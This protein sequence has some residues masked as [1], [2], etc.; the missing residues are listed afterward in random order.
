MTVEFEE[1]KPYGKVNPQDLKAFEKAN[2]VILPND[3]KRF[4]ATQNGGKPRQTTLQAVHTDVHWLYGMYDYD[5]APDWANFFEAIDTYSGR[6]PSWYVP[7]GRDS[8]GN[9]FIMSLYEENRGLVAW[10]LHE[11]EAK[12]YADDYFDNVRILADSFTEFL[13]LLSS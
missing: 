8:A 13:A 2:D 11:Q 10:W 9:L 6:L 4:L 12:D 5:N 3:Y 7:I 1:I